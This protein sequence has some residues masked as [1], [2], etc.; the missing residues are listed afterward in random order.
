MQQENQKIIERI[1]KLLALSQSS[2]EH[3]AAAALAKAQALL[4]EHNLTMAQVQARTGVKSSYVREV[5]WLAGADMWRR[6]LLTQ[7]ARFSFCDVVYWRGTPKV[8]VVGESENIQ[9]VRVMYLFIEEQ[10]E[11][12]AASG[13]QTYQRRGGQSHMRS[14]KTSFYQGALHTIGQRLRAERATLEAS[15]NACRALLVLKETDLKEAVA[16]FF[17]DVR[18]WNTPRR[19]TAPDGYTSGRQAGQRVRFRREV[20]EPPARWS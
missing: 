1:Q 5:W 16:S 19:V 14:W 8:S 10:L 17:P 2:N 6:D 7:L 9:A 12:F 4:V 13:F 18:V 20:S 11:R 3:E 15:T